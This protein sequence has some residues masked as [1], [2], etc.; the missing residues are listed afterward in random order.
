MLKTCLRSLSSPSLHQP[1][2]VPLIQPIF[3][4]RSFFSLGPGIIARGHVQFEAGYT[5]SYEH[6]TPVLMILLL[7]LLIRCF[8]R[9]LAMSSMSGWGFWAM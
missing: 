6:G 2:R 3:T 9:S 7:M 1:F 8:I 5:F 4:D